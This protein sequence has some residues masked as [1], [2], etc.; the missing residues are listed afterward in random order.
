MLLA[1][2]RWERLLREL[3]LEVIHAANALGFAIPE[4]LATKQIDRTRTMGAYKASTLID[5]EQGRPLELESLFFEPLRRA[6]AAG[7]A[8]P[9]LEKLCAILERLERSSRRGRTIRPSSTNTDRQLSPPGSSK[10]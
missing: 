5:F 7:V 8:V 6:Q 10:S 3:M 2:P 1:D 9:R 4:S